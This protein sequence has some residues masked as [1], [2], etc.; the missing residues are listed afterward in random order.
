MDVKRK[1]ERITAWGEEKNGKRIEI[2]TGNEGFLKIERVARKWLQSIIM[3]F[4][5]VLCAH[6]SECWIVSSLA[7]KQFVFGSKKHAQLS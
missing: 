1:N 7:V 5:L 2:R 4:S 3:T 6:F